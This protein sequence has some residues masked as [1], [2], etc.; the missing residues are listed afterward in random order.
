M[1][2]TTPYRRSRYI[3]WLRRSSSSFH[4]WPG[5][6]LRTM[7]C[8]RHR[9]SPRNDRL[10]GLLHYFQWRSRLKER[11]S[12]TEEA[13]LPRGDLAVA[14]QAPESTQPCLAKVRP[15]TVEFPCLRL[16]HEFGFSTEVA[17]L[18]V[19]PYRLGLDRQI[20]RDRLHKSSRTRQPELA[21]STQVGYLPAESPPG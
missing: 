19:Q 14:G 8:L 4:A 21:G 1:P 7:P 12:R 13:H 11:L 6:C 9:K 15:Y 17:C 10:Q 18:I 16:L 20:R 2:G 3:R 5:P